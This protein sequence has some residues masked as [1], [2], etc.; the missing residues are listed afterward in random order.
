MVA[1]HHSP[2]SRDMHSASKIL[3]IQF[4]YFGDAVLMT[5]ALRAIRE[6]FPACELH[7]L[8]PEEITPILQ[9]LPWLNRIWPKVRR[10]LFRLALLDRRP[11]GQQVVVMLQRQLHSLMQGNVAS[12]R[13]IAWLLSSE[14]ED[15]RERQVDW[16]QR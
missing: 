1:Q 6:H 8:V 5:P 9:H 4:K 12:G 13:S 15:S 14:G 16:Q 2:G 10:S 3:A 11:D 7:V